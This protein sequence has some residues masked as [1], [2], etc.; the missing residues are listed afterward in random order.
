MFWS[1]LVILWLGGFMLPSSLFLYSAYGYIFLYYKLHT[2][3]HTHTHKRNTHTQR[4]VQCL[5]SFYRIIHLFVVDVRRLSVFQ[6]V[7]Y[8]E[9]MMNWTEY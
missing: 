3:T 2:H 5:V 7:T 1:T 8:N 9:R 6:A 4:C